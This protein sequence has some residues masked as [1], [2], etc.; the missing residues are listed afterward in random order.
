M[1]KSRDP[2]K[3][4]AGQQWEKLEAVYE[5]EE[6]EEDEEELAPSTS[7]FFNVS[8]D[9]FPPLSGKISMETASSSSIPMAAETEESQKVTAKS[10]KGKNIDTPFKKLTTR[11]D[12]ITISE[13]KSG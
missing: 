10:Y 6:E 13:S 4:L 12:E 9:H 2:R 3:A 7:T 5:E 8:P 11:H 1:S